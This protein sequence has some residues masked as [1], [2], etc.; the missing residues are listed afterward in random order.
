MA[1]IGKQLKKDFSSALKTYGQ[2]V[3]RTRKS[4]RTEEGVL[5]ASS[6]L[7]L[8]CLDQPIPLHY[9]PDV[10][11]AGMTNLSANDF[12]DALFFLGNADINELDE[13]N[14]N[15]YSY[16]VS[17]VQPIII[18]DIEVIRIVNKIREQRS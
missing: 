15:G 5:V 18:N 17:F 11:G 12:K 8:R 4:Y 6:T 9:L 14:M 7:T 10:Y 13:L 3:L 2:T 16:R 1:S